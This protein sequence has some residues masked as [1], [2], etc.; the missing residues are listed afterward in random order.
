MALN[1]FVAR[2]GWEVGPIGGEYS[3]NERIYSLE[4]MAETFSF[5]QLSRSPSKVDTRKLDFY[6]RLHLSKEFSE[7]GDIEEFKKKCKEEIPEAVTSDLNEENWRRFM[8]NA[9]KRITTFKDLKEFSW[10]FE[11]KA[12]PS[13]KSKEGQSENSMELGQNPREG[14]FWGF[15]AEKLRELVQKDKNQKERIR[16]LSGFLEK[17]EAL[18]MASFE[19]E[20]IGKIIKESKGQEKD[21]LFYG[22]LR[23]SMTGSSDGFSLSDILMLIGAEEA[24]HRIKMTISLLEKL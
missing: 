20:T 12:E 22:S 6:T 19:A 10:V 18:S 24:T 5:S 11:R 3:K 17:L 14:S 1:N 8:V 13:G 15:G 16:I 2:L 9:G 7:K 21:K 23:L 4:E